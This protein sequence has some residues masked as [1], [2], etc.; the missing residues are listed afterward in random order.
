VLTALGTLAASGSCGSAR[1]E[2]VQ[3]LMGAAVCDPDETARKHAVDALGRLSAHAPP[4]PGAAGVFTRAV[5]DPSPGVRIRALYSLC[6]RPRGE[7]D[8]E[9]CLA[10]VALGAHD[11]HKG[12]REAA[13][14]A[15]S[16]LAEH[17]SGAVLL[18]SLALRD[19]SHEIREQAASALEH[20]GRKAAPVWTS[21]LS[22]A[23]HEN[24]D[25]QAAMFHAMMA[26]G[27]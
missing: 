1:E 4:P 14:Y 9:R 5:R 19:E 22:G 2:V 16:Q 8:E 11:A 24:P 10:A 6:S 26:T 25:L 21:L 20:L 23:Y 3:R 17:N 18:L 13:V 12:V 15:M 27:S 7:A